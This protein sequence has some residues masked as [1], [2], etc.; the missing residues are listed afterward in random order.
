[1]SRIGM[2]SSIRGGAAAA[3]SFAGVA[4][5]GTQKLT[6]SVQQLPSDVGRSRGVVVNISAAGREAAQ[7]RAQAPRVDQVR[8]AGGPRG[9]EQVQP[10][11][12]SLGG[13]RSLG[14]GGVL[15][16]NRIVSNGT[17]NTRKPSLLTSLGQGAT[18]LGQWNQGSVSSTRANRPGFAIERAA[19]AGRSADTLSA[20]LQRG[21]VPLGGWGDG[22]GSLSAISASRPDRDTEQAGAKQ[23]A[24]TTLLSRIAKGEQP[25]E[26]GPGR[27]IVRPDGQGTAG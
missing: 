13:S 19:D 17:A 23:R 24:A 16:G 1:M 4:R 3:G 7:K 12:L 8:P 21:D 26:T 25:L 18:P 10:R 14:E 6:T 27:H 9:V 5:A 11:L 2:L 20:R 22:R 15:S